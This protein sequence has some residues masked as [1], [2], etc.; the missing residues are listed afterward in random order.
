MGGFIRTILVAAVL[1]VASNPIQSQSLQIVETDELRLLYFDPTE[2]YLV[3]RIIQ[4]YHDSLDRQKSILGYTPAEKTTVLLTDFADYG[5]A[6]ANSVP[7]NSVV[8]DIAPVPFTFE[9]I[10]PAERMYTLMNH[11]MVHVATTDQMAPADSR[12]RRLFR[13][14]VLATAEHPETILYQYLTA[15][16][17]SSPRWFLEG[18]AVFQETWMAGGLGRSQGGYDE[19]VFRSKVGDN[20]HFYDPLGLV[21]EGVRVDFQ[22]GANAYL[23]GERFISYLAY[24][25]SPEKLVD[26]VVRTTDSKRNYE[27]EFVNVFGLTLDEVW[28]DWIEFERE[29]QARNLEAL[30]QFPITEHEDLASGA[31]GSVSR[32]FYDAD[33]N[34][35]IAGVRYPGV[36]AH[37]GEYSLE[38]REMDR[39][40]DIKVPMIYQVSSLAY[41]D[42]SKTIFYTADNYAYRDLMAIDLATGETRM[43]LEDERIGELAF[44]SSDRSI[45]GIRHLNGYAALVRVPY[46]YT[47]WNLIE[48]LP[49][50][51][52]AYDLDFSPDGSALSGSFGDVKGQQSLQVFRTEDL[53]AGHFEPVNTLD[54]GQAVPEGFVFSPDGQ[55]LFGSA[56]YT[57]VSNIFRYELATEELEAVSN[58]ETG[59]FR[60][61][62]VDNENLIVFRYTGQGFVPTRIK[63]EPVEDV[64][65]I[66]F[67]GTEVI[68]KHPQ[69]ETWRAGSPDSPP[70]ESRILST[71]DYVPLKNLRLESIYPTVLGYKDSESLSL[72]AIFSD[73]I[74]LDMLSI[75]AGYSI[76]SDLPTDE[77]LNLSIDYQHTVVSASPLSGTWRLG[78]RLNHADFY[79]MFGPTKTSRKGQRYFV[80][81]DKTL[82]FDEPRRLAFSAELNHHRDMDA[83]P[84]YQNVASTID[85]MSTFDAYLSYEHIRSS[86]G[87]VDGEKGFRWDLG[88]SIGYVDGDTI[89]Q[90]GG[91]FDFGFALPWKHSSIW[92]RNAAGAAFGE[93]DD[94]FAN[95]YFG[96]YGNNYVDRGIVKRYREFYALPGFELNAIPG[97]NF[98]R[99]MLEWNLPPIRFER[100][101]T[102]SFYLAWAR[103]SLFASALVTNADR[104][105]IRNNA[106]NIGMQ[107]DFRFT[108]NSRFNMTLST[109]YAKG[110]GEGSFTDDEWMISLKI[111]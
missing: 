80:A 40:R 100:V 32:A 20:A 34:S 82:I 56:Y 36:V 43:L 49:Y 23:Y 39:L 83:L 37:I 68:K 15:P 94:E 108:V 1:F 3:P 5:N 97:R 22:V 42:E 57:G 53:L 105:E 48:S 38:T 35:L 75:G 65:A 7:A 79:D 47:E 89:P 2:T 62:P 44:N 60:P 46:P 106:K 50:G 81:Y 101:G 52:V 17:K 19:M 61:I 107:I 28:Q 26:W 24:T 93:P 6:G 31:L 21:S 41:D 104:S 92:L 87:A 111:M 70:A 4:T 96:G 54:F 29:F 14:K 25:W 91:S 45:W 95:F 78:A 63:A 9:T 86:L 33:R 90:V 98:Y 66:T 10:A 69:L 84:R 102:P 74:R 8:V 18:I 103:P 59:F 73:P 64:A 11:E 55:Y 76:D 77:R 27:N 71:G 67:F 88:T 12:Y 85:E 109:G 72:K 30:R 110:Y 13:G 58:T 99:G 51:E 16:R